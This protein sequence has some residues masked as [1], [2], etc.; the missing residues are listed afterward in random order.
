MYY[1]FFQLKFVI[2]S[3][4][5]FLCIHTNCID[6]MCHLDHMKRYALNSCEMLID[7]LTSD[8]PNPNPHNERLKREILETHNTTVN[9]KSK[10]F[11][12]ITLSRK[13]IP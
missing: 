6:A 13:S 7:A 8:Y 12:S 5:Y 1:Y 4:I 10:L 2:I 11:F 9:C 3:A